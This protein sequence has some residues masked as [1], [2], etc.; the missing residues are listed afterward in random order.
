MKRTTWGAS[1][2]NSR[3]KKLRTTHSY[4]TP[5]FDTVCSFIASDLSKVFQIFPKAKQSFWLVEPRDPVMLKITCKLF[6]SF[7]PWPCS[8]CSVQ[9]KFQKSAERKQTAVWY[10]ALRIICWIKKGTQRGKKKT[11]T[12]TTLA[13]LSVSWIN[14]AS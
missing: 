4:M 14:V 10:W 6:C 3:L 9:V 11:K 8:Q 1:S 13:D 7:P 5:I 2:R 12:K